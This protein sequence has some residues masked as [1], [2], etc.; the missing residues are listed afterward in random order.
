MDA[1]GIAVGGEA[2]VLFFG[3][4]IDVEVATGGFEDNSSTTAIVVRNTVTGDV[5]LNLNPHD[6]IPRPLPGVVIEPALPEVEVGPPAPTPDLGLHATNIQAPAG[7]KE[8]M[9][10]GQAEVVISVNGEESL[11]GTF[12]TG[13]AFEALE[14]LL[15]PSCQHPW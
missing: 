14:Y 3:D 6:L 10:S 1:N 13:M 15:D 8:A 9:E 4:R 2:E 12:M 11:V 7:L 5:S